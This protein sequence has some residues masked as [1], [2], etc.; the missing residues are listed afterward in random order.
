MNFYFFELASTTGPS[1]ELGKDNDWREVREFE[2]QEPEGM[3][4]FAR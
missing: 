4:F 2:V 1:D 3:E